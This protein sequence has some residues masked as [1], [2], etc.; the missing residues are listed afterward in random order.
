MYMYTYIHKICIRIS[1]C[2]LLDNVCMYILAASHT[3]PLYPRDPG[4]CMFTLVPA[5]TR[6]AHARLLG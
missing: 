3:K 6:N 5:K 2:N 1:H 4:A